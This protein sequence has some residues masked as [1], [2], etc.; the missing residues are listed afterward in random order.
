M[1]KGRG[2]LPDLHP[3]VDAVQRGNIRHSGLSNVNVTIP[4]Q[5]ELI[6]EYPNFFADFELR[7]RL[8]DAEGSEQGTEPV[9]KGVLTEVE[10]SG[11]SSTMTLKTT[12]RGWSLEKDESIVE[13]EA[14]EVWRA[15]RQYINEE[16]AFDADVQP[17]PGAPV[18]TD[19]IA[20]SP[21]TQ[22]EWVELL[23]DE[24]ILDDIPVTVEDGQ[25]VTQQSAWI[26]EGQDVA[27]A[28]TVSDDDY[29]D[30]AAAALFDTGDSVSRSVTVD[31][32]IPAGE[33]EVI[34]RGRTEGSGLDLEW[35]FDSEDLEGPF[36][37]GS[38]GWQTVE[39]PFEI[40]PGTYT[41]TI[42]GFQG[43]TSDPEVCD[44][45]GMRDK[46]WDH[47]LS[48]EL[49]EPGG[50]LPGPEPKP[51]GVEVEFPLINRET[52]VSAARIESVWNNTSDAQAIAVSNNDGEDYVEESNTDSLDVDFRDVD[53]DLLGTNIRA[54]VTFGRFEADGPR[55][56]TPKLGYS[57]QAID[58]IEVRFDQTSVAIVSQNGLVLSEDD[59]QNIKDLA[60]IARYNF[61]IDH[62]A[63]DKRIEA[64]PI[65]TEGEDVEWVTKD[66]SRTDGDADYA[67]RVVARGARK[68][69]DERE[70]E[71]DI[72]FEASVTDEDEI[73]R[74]TDL[75]LSEEEAT[76]STVVTDP[77]WDTQDVV[78]QQAFG[79]LAGVV[80]SRLPSGQLDIVPTFVK[81]GYAYP[82]AEF[83]DGN[84][85]VPT[86]VLE[87]VRYSEE[88]GNARG[89]LRFEPVQNWVEAVTPVEQDVVG[90]KRLF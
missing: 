12:G 32:T 15:L 75:G 30:G 80:E 51:S 62:T 37:F 31:Y 36:S 72:R 10:T 25:L 88:Y 81:P 13:F 53:E 66:W 33:A 84:G 87:Q 55:D 61:V 60:N 19:A 11:Q 16:T 74:L 18:V 7:V 67:N 64:F 58:E 71:D 35:R 42:E 52:L 39:V 23:E 69:E 20:Y 28:S 89:T 43:N 50:A 29:S 5:S 65:G 47:T 90:I 21:S 27:S 82:I 9:F 57:S 68:P 83:E 77:E 70:D 8:T 14:V 40:E 86:K 79:A 73:E 76:V 78:Q 17:D 1:I 44:L 4:A 24:G 6:R 85:D 22:T 45:V 41:V 54:R 46:R 48:N 26:S 56:E 59:L 3:P 34:A 63:D 2:D 49:D 38:L